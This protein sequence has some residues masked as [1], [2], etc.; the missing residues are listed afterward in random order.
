LQ[1]GG[2]PEA[3]LLRAGLKA[4]RVG[5]AV[6]RAAGT[7]HAFSALARSPSHLLTLVQRGFTDVGLGE[8]IDDEKHTCLVVLLAEWPRYVGITAPAPEQAR[9]APR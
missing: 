9:V 6:A 2:D 3:R 4:R 1:A 5:E 8:A 7:G